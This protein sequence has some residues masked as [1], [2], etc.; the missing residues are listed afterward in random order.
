MHRHL[1]RQAAALAQGLVLGEPV[2]QEPL[3]FLPDHRVD[4]V[5]LVRGAGDVDRQ[6]A[7][8]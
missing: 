6:I 3:E 2:P 5:E 1:I 8:I 7:G 4:L